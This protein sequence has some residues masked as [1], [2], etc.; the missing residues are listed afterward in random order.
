M[1]SSLQTTALAADIIGAGK[2]CGWDEARLT[3]I[4]ETELERVRLAERE[5]CAPL[6]E[7][8]AERYRQTSRSS[9]L[10]TGHDATSSTAIRGLTV[11]AFLLRHLTHTLTAGAD[12][13]NIE[14]ELE[15]TRE[16]QANVQ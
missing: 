7:G 15:Q 10:R 8:Y 16:E 2:D 4:I 3:E 6:L 1:S 5:G 14:I 12:C 11:G 13:L 9:F